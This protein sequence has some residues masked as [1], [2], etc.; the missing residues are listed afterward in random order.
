MQK[1]QLTKDNENTVFVGDVTILEGVIAENSENEGIVYFNYPK[2]EYIN[3]QFTDGSRTAGNYNT[4]AQM[5]ENL[6]HLNFFTFGRKRI[7][8]EKV[9]TVDDLKD[10]DHVG[11]VAYG[12]KGYIVDIEGKISSIYADHDDTKWRHTDQDSVKDALCV[13]LEL[14]TLD[15][16]YKFPTRKSLYKWLSE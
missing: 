15:L 12:R 11:F 13:D 6:S 10:T 2:K 8:T 14:Y 7:V 1:V 3:V 5:M 4:L 9:L 16:V